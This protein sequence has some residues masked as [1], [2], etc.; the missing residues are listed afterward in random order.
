MMHPGGTPW[1][2]PLEADLDREIAPVLATRDD[3]E[4]SELKASVG[5]LCLAILCGSFGSLEHGRP[6]ASAI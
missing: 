4:L 1:R 3:S 6:T 2:V 5:G